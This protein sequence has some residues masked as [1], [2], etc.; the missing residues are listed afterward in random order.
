MHAPLLTAIAAFGAWAGGRQVE[1]GDV[2]R[3]TFQSAP[4]ESVLVHS[5]EDLRGA[6]ALFEFWGPNCSGCVQGAIPQALELQETWGEDLQVV[7]VEVQGAGEDE[8]ARFALR[9]RWFGGRA[10]WTSEAPFWPGGNRLPMA[11][12]LGNDGRVLWKGNP[13]AQSREIGRLVAGEVRLR[14]APPATAPK[15]LRSAWTEFQRGHVGRASA[16]LAAFERATCEEPT[17]QPDV[18]REIELLRR[19]IDG[20]F[21]Q[22]AALAAAGH[23]EAFDAR[24][25][26]LRSGAG[27]DA[28]TRARV[29]QLAA[30][31]SG[32]EAAAERAAERR[33][34]RIL[35][36]CFDSGGGGGAARELTAFAR[37]HEGTRAAVRAR[38]WARLAEPAPPE[39]A[40]R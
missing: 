14:R 27:G 10:I 39:P 37:E 35:A 11:V 36:R 28:P 24:L 3:Y 21:A 17:A 32:P 38:D 12:L 31:W 9:Q 18:V 25:E 19:A 20:R 8:A 4:R 7:F 30:S 34:G 15:G 6:P 13:T 29:E 1:V 22:V 16:L 26:G 23:F 33:L 2:P 5:L 40:R